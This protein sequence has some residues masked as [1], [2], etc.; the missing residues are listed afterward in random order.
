MREYGGFEGNAQ[1]LRILSKL[2][3]KVANT[4][5]TLTYD[6]RLGLNLTYRTLAS[7]LKYDKMIPHVRGEEDSLVK[8]YYADEVE[9]VTKIKSAVEP[10]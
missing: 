7:T 9:L 5:D 10:N 2:E 1:T 3:K 8:G 4:G 6:G